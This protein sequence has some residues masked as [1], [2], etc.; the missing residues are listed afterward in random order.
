MIAELLGS[1]NRERVL[2][3]ILTSKEGYAKE[4]ADFYESSLDPIQKQLDR[5]E[6]AS[7]LV[8]KKVG[9][10]R[11]FMF[12]PRYAFLNELKALLQKAVE[13]YPPEEIERLTMKR[14]RP[15]RKD[16]PL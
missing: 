9:R 3:Y 8:S 15:R 11:V 7:V 2:V 6:L 4:I 12:N 5:L 10:T 14:K 16:K 13:F 1:K